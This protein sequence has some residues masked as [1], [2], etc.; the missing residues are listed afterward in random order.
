MQ[1]EVGQTNRDK[2]SHFTSRVVE[3]N[4]PVDW[5][6]GIPGLAHSAKQRKEVAWQA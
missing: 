3:G 1:E 6:D 4:N 5:L 2:N